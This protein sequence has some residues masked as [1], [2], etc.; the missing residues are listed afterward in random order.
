MIQPRV[1]SLCS[2]KEVF[3]LKETIRP[4]IEQ[5]ERYRENIRA[6]RRL[7]AVVAGGLEADSDDTEFSMWEKHLFLGDSK[8]GQASRARMRNLQV[9]WINQ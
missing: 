1:Y 6:A 7:G 4:E 3:P 8:D 9:L 2:Q 5:R